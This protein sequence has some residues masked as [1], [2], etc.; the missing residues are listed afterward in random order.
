MSK[1]R[2]IGTW[3]STEWQ[4][5]ATH[6]VMARQFMWSAKVKPR[7]HPPDVTEIPVFFYSS[8]VLKATAATP[9]ALSIAETQAL[10]ELEAYV[11]EAT[12]GVTYLPAIHLLGMI[13]QAMS[14]LIDDEVDAQ[15]QITLTDQD[16][17][18]FKQKLY[19]AVE[20]AYL[21]FNT[22]IQEAKAFGFDP[23]THQADSPGFRIEIEPLT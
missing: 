4:T 22:K 12:Q 13:T 5:P 19:D 7:V 8:A 21:E 10:S 3:S 17:E 6:H 9:D 15:D 16:I 14:D 1:L 20:A 23:N 2:Q 18:G 11:E